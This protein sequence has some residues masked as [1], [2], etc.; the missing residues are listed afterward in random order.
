MIILNLNKVN[1]YKYINYIMKIWV[2]I[3]FGFDLVP[4]HFCFFFC[5]RD[6]ESTSITDKI[7]TFEPNIVFSVWFDSLFFFFD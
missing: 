5:S 3:R 1:I 2:S 6:K 7:Q 4:I